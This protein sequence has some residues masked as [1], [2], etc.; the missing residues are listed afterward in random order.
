MHQN[1]SL[2]DM[3]AAFLSET[4]EMHFVQEPFGYA[5][6]KFLPDNSCY[7]VEGYVLPEFRRQGKSKVII[8]KVYEIA[9]QKK[10]DKLFSS[11]GTKVKNAARNMKMLISYGMEL[12]SANSDIIYF[13][14]E[15]K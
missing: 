3:Y 14:K 6:Y 9:K 13:V 15:I 10:C 1:N 7:V 8:D 2:T 12:H 5:M 4:E 11:V